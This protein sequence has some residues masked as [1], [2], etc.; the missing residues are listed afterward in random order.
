MSSAVLAN[1]KVARPAG[2]AIPQ[3]VNIGLLL[4]HTGA[5]LFQ[6][7]ILPIYFLSANPWW[8]LALAPVAALNNPLW[9]AD[10]RGDARRLP[11]V[12]GRQSS[13][14]TL[15]IGAVRLAL[16]DFAPDSFIAPQV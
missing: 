6:L 3:A 2:L 14:G 16:S 8:A 4:L 13:R 15:A 1:N 12:V 5:N 11:F 9:G 10:A 7:F